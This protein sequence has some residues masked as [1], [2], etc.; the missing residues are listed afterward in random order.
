MTGQ[1]KNHPHSLLN[2]MTESPARL[3]SSLTPP[4]CP[5]WATRC[6]AIA[7]PMAS[8]CAVDSPGSALG[9]G[10]WRGAA[11]APSAIGASPARHAQKWQ[12][13]AAV[14]WSAAATAHIPGVRRCGCGRWLPET[15]AD[16]GP[17]VALDLGSPSP[18]LAAPRAGSRKN[19][20]LR[21]PLPPSSPC[22]PVPLPSQ[23]MI[24]LSLWFFH[25]TM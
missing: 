1:M 9:A 3:R 2:D 18:S 13:P 20:T 24:I 10:P 17:Q 4:L 19:R 8:S 5:K 7:V 16:P 12:R 25:N 22:L 6:W 21:G 11:A 14:L 23:G 15:R